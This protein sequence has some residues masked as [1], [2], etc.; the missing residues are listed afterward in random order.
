MYE[1]MNRIEFIG[2][3][4]Y[5]ISAFISQNNTICLKNIKNINEIYGLCTVR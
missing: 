4:A 2:D 1:Y 3:T 5:N